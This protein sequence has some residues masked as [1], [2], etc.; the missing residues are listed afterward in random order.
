GAAVVVDDDDQLAVL[1]DRDVV[2]RLP[3]HAAGER[4]VAD[5][6]DDVAVFAAQGVG[7]GQ[8]VGV[9]QRGRGVGVLHDVVVGLGL[10]GIAGQAALGAEGVEPGGP[11]GQHL[12]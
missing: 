12:V 2:E 4:A 9:G 6:G 8:P 7:L 3:G 5:Q 10:A 11:A 1:A